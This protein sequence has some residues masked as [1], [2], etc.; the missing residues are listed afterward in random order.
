MCWLILTEIWQ[1]SVIAVTKDLLHSENI[2]K[3]PSPQ[4]HFLFSPSPLIAQSFGLLESLQ[5]HLPGER[6]LRA[7]D[8]GCGSGREA[9]VL[10][11]LGW[12]VTGLDRDRRGLNRWIDLAE[13][14]GCRHLCHPLC[15]TTEKEGDLCAKLQEAAANKEDST[16]C[17]W[18]L[19]TVNRHLHRPTLAEISSLL[20]PGGLLLYHTFM[21]VCEHPPDMKSKL[22]SGELKETF[23]PPLEVLR[24][25]ELAV[26]DGRILS[27]FVAKKPEGDT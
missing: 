3:G 5:T 27:F 19:I 18:H 7:L 16:T 2:E 6:P 24:D 22:R 25:E 15:I 14:Q 8:I 26:D 9:I 1:A 17:L 23:S 21:E 4:G 11:T 12:E 20:A 10:A 13:R